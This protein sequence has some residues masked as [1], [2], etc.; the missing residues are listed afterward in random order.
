MIRDSTSEVLRHDIPIVAMTAHALKGDRERCLEA[1]MD[2]YVSKPVTPLG[3]GE[4]LDRHLENPASLGGSLSKEGPSQERPVEIEQIREVADG[5]PEFEREL[6]ETFLT[7]SEEQIQSLE[8]ALREKDADEIR[9]R[10]HTIKGSSANAGAKRLQEVACEMERI[11]SS[12]ELEEAE[13]VFSLLRAAF[14]QAREYLQAHLRSD[15]S[16]TEEHLQ[17]RSQDPLS[18]T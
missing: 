10:A 2:D 5:D 3:L 12:N 7:D 15:G 18:G 9:V 11:G 4:I 6:I 13:A 17:D 14:E 16:S 8:V 1:G